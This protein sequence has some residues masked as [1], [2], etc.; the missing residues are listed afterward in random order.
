MSVAFTREESAETAAEVVLPDRPIS[1]HP[2][3]VTASGLEALA[4]A[5]AEW[6]ADYSAAQQIEDADERRRA[7]AVASREMRY[8][9]GTVTLLCE[10]RDRSG[11]YGFSSRRDGLTP[12]GQRRGA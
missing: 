9:A 3:L 7:V 8:F 5:M 1:P 4:S 6:R 2:N 11:P 12:R 10:E